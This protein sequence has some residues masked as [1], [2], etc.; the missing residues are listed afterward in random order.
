[1]QLKFFLSLCFVGIMIIHKN[2]SAAQS[3]ILA[4]QSIKDTFDY[5]PNEKTAIKIAEAIW[6]PIYG[7]RIYKNKPFVATLVNNEIW[8]VRGTMHSEK[9]GVPYA[10]IQKKDCKILKVI[11][12]K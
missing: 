4:T 8:V 7:N 6:L 5:V 2:P 9:G 10:E 3:A 11:H 12:G 1:M